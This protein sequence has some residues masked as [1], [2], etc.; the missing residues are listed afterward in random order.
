MSVLTNYPALG[1]GETYTYV[2]RFE[3]D[4]IL[5]QLGG[6]IGAA[7]GFIHGYLG[8]KMLS[9]ATIE[10]PYAKRMARLGWQCGAVAWVAVGVLLIAAA[11][12]ESA[13]ARRSV[14]IAS[15]VIYFAGATGNMIASKGKHIGWFILTVA[16]GLTLA[17][18]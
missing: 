8:E 15:V 17:G 13:D 16:M 14:I 7:V 18:W 12:F 9:R 11:G 10:P 3:M 5:M 6:A 4:H 1:I 2:W